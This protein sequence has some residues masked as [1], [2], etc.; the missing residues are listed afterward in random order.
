MSSKKERI[1]ELETIVA[2]LKQENK[3][4]NDAMNA[5]LIDIRDLQQFK[6]F[7]EL[8]HSS[9]HYVNVPTLAMNTTKA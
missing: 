6:R 5:I 1:A 8:S 7:I 2:E 9:Q 4:L 3:E